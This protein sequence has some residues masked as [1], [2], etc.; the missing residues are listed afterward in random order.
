MPNTPARVRVSAGSGTL[1]GDTTLAI[2]SDALGVFTIP[3]GTWRYG[4]G[5]VTQG[6]QVTVTGTSSWPLP[7][8]GIT[9]VPRYP[10]SWGAP[11]NVTPVTLAGDTTAGRVRVMLRDQNS[12]GMPN[13]RVRA[14][15][16][17][18]G[19]VG[20]SPSDGTGG[21]TDT[22]LVTDAAGYVNVPLWRFGPA[23]PNYL[24]QSVT[25]SV[26]TRGLLTPSW[27]MPAPYVVSVWPRAPYTIAH[28]DLRAWPPGNMP[29]G[30]NEF[31][32]I[33]WV[34][35][36]AAG[37]PL[38]GVTV[39]VSL[40]NS[41]AWFANPDGS[42]MSTAPRVLVTNAQGIVFIPRGNY[43]IADL[44]DRSGSQTVRAE[45]VGTG[46]YGAPVWQ[47][48]WESVIIRN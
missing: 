47:Q 15:V 13:T 18:G 41:I 32:D 2:R 39:R 20:G 23:N 1:N 48:T 36:D 46:P 6:L 5:W 29:G 24:L 9:M 38:P 11:A 22:V 42:N 28:T 26:D 45:V 35:K 8:L 21:S 12:V 19:T 14:V 37:L 40:P 25:L 3:A 27:A 44:G 31:L 43:W 10:Y 34:V 16:A 7:L 30:S 4:H 33:P 17:G